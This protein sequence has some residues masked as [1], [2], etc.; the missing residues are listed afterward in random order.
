MKQIFEA[1]DLD[2]ALGELLEL[3]ERANRTGVYRNEL[4]P[5][6][7]YDA[8]ALLCEQPFEARQ[9]WYEILT[10]KITRPLHSIP[11]V[12]PRKRYAYIRP[13]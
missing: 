4:G 7:F 13:H 2:W 8:W 5:E 1:D 12:L 11:H 10:S 3:F 9:R 6:I